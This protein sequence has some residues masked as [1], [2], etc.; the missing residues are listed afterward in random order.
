MKQ[1]LTSEHHG[2]ECRMGA[3]SDGN[4]LCPALSNRSVPLSMSTSL[5]TSVPPAGVIGSGSWREE[6]GPRRIPSTVRPVR[7]VP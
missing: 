7:L 4:T 1:G 6:L 5:T 3:A 2:D